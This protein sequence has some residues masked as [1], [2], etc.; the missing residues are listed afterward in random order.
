MKNTEFNPSELESSELEPNEIGPSEVKAFSFWVDIKVQNNRRKR[1]QMY[2]LMR[3]PR[4]YET[5]K[6]WLCR[7]LLIIV[8]F[9]IFFHA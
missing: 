4:I 2:N 1:R 7:T 3:P 8:T 6:A 5:P 9:W